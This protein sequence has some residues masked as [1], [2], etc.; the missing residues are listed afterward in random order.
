MMFQK[1][2]SVITT[3]GH[4]IILITSDFF[5]NTIKC[6]YIAINIVELTLTETSH[7]GE[8]Y[9]VLFLLSYLLSINNS[10][11]YK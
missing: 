2:V 8:F 11:V 7:I 9:G 10:R 5:N 1:V 4:I 6:T 3:Y